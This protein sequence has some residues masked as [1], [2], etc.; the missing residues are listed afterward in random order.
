M[1]FALDYYA[2]S[3]I[4]VA[5]AVVFAAFATGCAGPNAIAADAQRVM[6][7]D[8]Q[9]GE[10]RAALEKIMRL[11]AVVAFKRGER[12]PV[13][14]VLDSS[15]L[16]LV[17]GDL[18]LMAKRDFYLLLRADGGPLLSEDGVDFEAGDGPKNYFFF[19]FAVQRDAAT[20]VKVAIGVR[21]ERKL[22]E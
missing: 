20:S 2:R 7:A 11:P 15:M 17:R 6:Y 1:H 22:P 4:S 19:G 5:L 16:E 21:P 8:L 9:A 3:R 10:R 12:I 13:E 18:E 14:F